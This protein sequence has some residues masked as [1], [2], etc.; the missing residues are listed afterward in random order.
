[1]NFEYRQSLDSRTIDV[2]SKKCLKPRTYRGD[3]NG[4]GR[5][6][7]WTETLERP[8]PETHPMYTAA[9]SKTIFVVIAVVIL[10]GCASHRLLETGSFACPGVGFSRLHHDGSVVCEDPAGNP[11]AIA[12]ASTPDGALSNL[13]FFSERLPVATVV[14]FENG[15]ISSLS[16]RAVDANLEWLLS[17][18]PNGQLMR[19]ST[20]Q[21]DEPHGESRAWH[22]NGLLKS[23]GNYANGSKV[24]FW[25]YFNQNGSLVRRVSENSSDM[26]PPAPPAAVRE[27]GLE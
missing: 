26:M 7:R 19:F 1:M 27:G 8:P 15:Q 9:H 11:L 25:E 5:S 23:F 6:E 13:T 16:V 17:W 10:T 18:Y 14:F 2:S 20:F 24:G 12:V 21:S 3:S 22:E 4:W